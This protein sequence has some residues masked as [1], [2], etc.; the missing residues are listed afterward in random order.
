MT[1]EELGVRWG[2]REGGGQVW[3]MQASPERRVIEVG[4]YPEAGPWQN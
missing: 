3:P 4:V 2:A 1:E